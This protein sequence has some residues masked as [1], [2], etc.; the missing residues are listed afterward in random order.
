MDIL[1]KDFR[2]QVRIDLHLP[3]VKDEPHG[4]LARIVPSRSEEKARFV[5]AVRVGSIALLGSFFLFCNY[6]SDYSFSMGKTDAEEL[7]L[8]P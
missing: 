6:F 5:T 7:L 4:P 2:Y 8:L 1:T 3:N